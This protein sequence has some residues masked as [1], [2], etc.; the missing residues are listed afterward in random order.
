M[1]SLLNRCTTIIM[2]L[3]GRTNVCLKY[4][5]PT[6]RYMATA[7]APNAASGETTIKT[8]KPTETPIPPLNL[9]EP[10]HLKSIV[11]QIS[12]LR[13]DEITILN[14]ILK[15]ELKIPDVQR[16]VAT[17][18]MTAAGAAGEKEADEDSAVKSNYTVKLVKFDDSKK[19]ALIKEIKKLVEGIN[20]VEAKRFVEECPR[21]IR[22]NLSKDEA[23]TLQKQLEAAGG[24]VKLE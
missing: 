14:E 5:V 22:S 3:S 2:S 24:S 16:V 11:D 4:L 6:S 21:V 20:L 19:V 18:Q 23:E 13:F 1:A 9:A 10:A 15:R 8:Q 12:K 17:G 7:A